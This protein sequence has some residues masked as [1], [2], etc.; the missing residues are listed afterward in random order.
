MDIAYQLEHGI[1]YQG[2]VLDVLKGLPDESVHMC[3]TSPPYWGLRDYKSPPQVW[4]DPGGCEHELGDETIKKITSQT[5]NN[6]GTAFEA[7]QG[8]FCQFCCAWRG[9]LGLEPSPDLYVK[10]IV[11][12]FRELRRVLRSDG[13]LWLNL[14]D[15]YASGKGLCS[16]PGGGDDSFDGYKRRKDVGAYNLNR[17]N[18]SDLDNMGLKLKDLVGIPWR[19]ALALQAD[20]WYLRSDII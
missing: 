5:K 8:Q 18:K 20:G 16:N 7:S 4:D 17:L 11:Q 1:I 14:G 10:H 12:I 9:S 19:V 2:H 13:T 15:S 3:I 6:I